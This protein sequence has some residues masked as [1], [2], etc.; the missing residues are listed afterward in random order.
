[1]CTRFYRFPNNQGIDGCNKCPG[2]EGYGY[3]PDTEWCADEDND[4]L[5]DPSTATAGCYPEDIIGSLYDGPNVD[6]YVCTEAETDEQPYCES[7][8]YCGITCCD[9]NGVHC[10]GN[11]CCEVGATICDGNNQCCDPGVLTLDVNGN[12]CP[13]DAE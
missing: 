1:M 2:D 3:G 6:W 8:Y 11:E 12:C 5:I 4:G 10:C 13:P 7:N 9:V